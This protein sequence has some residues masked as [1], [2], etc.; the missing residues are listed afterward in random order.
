MIQ[1]CPSYMDAGPIDGVLATIDCQTRVYA[2]G[3][4]EALTQGSGLFGAALTLLLTIYVA[5]IGWRLL[6]AP[7]GARLSEAPGVALRIGAILA[8]V[9]NWS[10]FQTLVFDVAD[11]APVQIAAAVSAP[12]TSGGEGRSLAARPVAGLERA[13]SE[14]RGAAAAFGVLAPPNAKAYASSDAASAEAL[15]LAADALMVMSVGVVGGAKLAIGVLTAVGPVFIALALLNVT[16]GVFF[17]WV[18]ALAGSAL[19]LLV[20]WALLIMLLVVLAPWLAAL[21]EQRQAQVL[22]PRTATSLAALILVFAVGQGVLILAAWV[23]ALG[24][25]MGTAPATPASTAVGTTRPEPAAALQVA[26]RA[27]RLAQALTQDGQRFESRVR[28]ITLA[29]AAVRQAPVQI[30]GPRPADTIGGGY[31]RPVATRRRG[32]A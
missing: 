3:G 31:R 17:G 26:S 32:G 22:D 19:S 14:L 27:D 10:V 15:S 13:H 18:R 6:V 25:K 9:T 21:A 24:L 20:G 28:E 12:W 4:Y 2:Q 11:R 29:G 7:A 16:R 30:A 23:A 8:L 1:A 5:L